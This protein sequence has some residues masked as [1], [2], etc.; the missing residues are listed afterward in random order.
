MDA[1]TN[2]QPLCVDVRQAAEMI[3]MST[4]AVREYIATGELPTVKLPSTKGAE[5][6]SRRVLIAVDDLRA[7]IARFRS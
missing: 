1:T 2:L 5:S 6:R 3:G 4:W 7:F